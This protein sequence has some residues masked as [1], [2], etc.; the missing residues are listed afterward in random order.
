MPHA[1]ILLFLHPEDKNHSVQHL[2]NIISA[3]IPNKDIDPIGFKAVQSF[4]VHGPCGELNKEAK[5]M[6][7]GKCTK[8]F[9]KPF[10]AV[11]TFDSD[12]FPLYRRRDLGHI[13]EQNGFIFNNQYVV[14]HNRNLIVKYNAHINVELCNHSR[15]IKYLFKYVNKGP[16]R[17]TAILDGNDPNSQ[18][19]IKAHLDCRYLSSTKAR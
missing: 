18:D 10:N 15:A 3:E 9:P 7:N 17:A 11:T 1:H 8:H 5:C 16:D 12:G 6:A 13:V 2:D 19:E 4:M 14:P